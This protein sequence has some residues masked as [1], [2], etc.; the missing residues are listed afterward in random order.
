MPKA[1]SFPNSRGAEAVVVRLLSGAW[2]RLGRSSLGQGVL[3][4]GL[5]E[6]VGKRWARTAIVE[7]MRHLP[8]DVTVLIGIR[9]RTDYRI[10][11]A[12]RCVQDQRYPW[13]RVHALVVDYGSEPSQAR[14]LEEICERRGAS[15]LRVEE[16]GI[17][18]RGRCLNVGLRRTTTKFVMTSDAD[19]LLS[20]HY[21]ADA[22]AT[23]RARPLSVVC[24]PML[25]LPEESRETLQRIARDEEPLD[26]DALSPR[27]PVRKGLKLHPSAGVTF[28]GFHHAIR[29]YDE[30]Y[31]GWGRE[32]DD[33]MSRLM[34]LGIHMIAAPE[35]SFYLHQWHPKYE[36]LNAE[37]QARS[38][39]RNTAHLQRSRSIVR[40]GEDWGRGAMGAGNGSP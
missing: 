8:D 23:L 13:G 9:N 14:A 33:L 34:A 27:C 12:L 2:S 28:T 22:V 19:L 26:V 6:A 21:L 38:V 7:R 15:L 11:N 32:D 25:D 17:W 5:L 39:E 10:I 31:E 1:P 29:G 24:S 18:S 35:R 36:G 40:N 16:P 30:F 3:G 37:E 4:L 20:S